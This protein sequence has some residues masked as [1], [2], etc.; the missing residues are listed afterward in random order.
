MGCL[1]AKADGRRI[2]SRN[3]HSSSCD[4]FQLIE[5][6]VVLVIVG[7]VMAVALPDVGGRNQWNRMEGAARIF[8]ARLQTARALAVSRRV[9]YRVT[10]SPMGN[11][12]FIERA[13]TDSTWVLEP[14]E[15]YAVEGVDQMEVD[16]DGDTDSVTVVLEPRGTVQEG[17]APALVRFLDAHSDTAEVSL[18]R[19]GR[20]TVRLARVHA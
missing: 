6:M 7:I 12:Y 2:R 17:D 20:V 14:N 1:E 5:L 4:G 8:S 15:V 18:V 3:R 19:T 9:P 10:V 11:S 13:D 16:I